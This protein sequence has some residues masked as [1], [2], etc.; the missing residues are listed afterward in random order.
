MDCFCIVVIV[1]I[2]VIAAIFIYCK[3]TGK[4]IY[5]QG[6]HEVK[7]DGKTL[8]I[9]NFQLLKEKLREKFP[10]MDTEEMHKCANKIIEEF[11]SYMPDGLGYHDQAKWLDKCIKKYIKILSK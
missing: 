5:I 7:H 9:Q 11:I 8:H 4:N 3:V 1:A 10:E 2:I 6:G